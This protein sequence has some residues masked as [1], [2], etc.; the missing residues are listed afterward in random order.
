MTKG[1][2]KA[3]IIWLLCASVITYC[4]FYIANIYL[5]RQLSLEEYGD[6]AVSLKVLAVLCAFLTISKQLSLSL[7]M[8]QYE[9]SHRHIQRNGLALW[10]GKNLFIAITVLLTGITLTQIVLYILKNK[11]FVSVFQH[12]PWQFILF[13]IP[14]VAFFTV[15]SCLLLSQKQLKNFYAPF[16][17]IIPSI[18]IVV[19][20]TLAIHL[21]K[22][23]PKLTIYTYFLCQS[24]TFMLYIFLSHNYH[25][26]KFLTNISQGEHGQWYTSPHIYWIGTLSNQISTLLSLIALELLSPEDFVG[27]YAIILLFITGYIA[28]ISP[29]HTYLASQLGLLLHTHSEKLNKIIKLIVKI[30]SLIVIVGTSICIAF[31]RDLLAYIDPN[32]VFLYP[33][34]IFAM[35]MFGIA[36]TTAIP[37]RILLHAS[38]SE[39]GMHLKISR[40][41][42][43]CLF[44]SILVPRYGIAGA[45]ISDTLPLIITNMIA[46]SI[47]KRNLNIQFS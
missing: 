44:L 15:L 2:P 40:L 31:G 7:Y 43:C 36:I 23:S 1:Y 41:F 47:C 22:F 38:L 6:F 11:T 10:L 35:I 4:F 25:I 34:L 45:I 18:L 14:I 24:T 5:V 26:P 42:L 8:P 28:L 20:F 21:L 37:L 27:E 33:Q 46:L 9:K 17:T 12:H 16:I 19:I 13:F 32:V 39:I 30:Q 29:L 3:K